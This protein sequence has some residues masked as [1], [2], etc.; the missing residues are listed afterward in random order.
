MVHTKKAP[1]PYAGWELLALVQQNALVPQSGGGSGALK[2]L[3]HAL[4]QS[5]DNL[6]LEPRVLRLPPK[7][8]R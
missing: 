3:A 5:R 2:N 1:T 8:Q 4:L 6:L 7:I